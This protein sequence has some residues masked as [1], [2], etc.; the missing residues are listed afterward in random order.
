M[1]STGM[2]LAVLLCGLVNAANLPPA[3]A[4]E[5]ASTRTSASCTP[6]LIP[7]VGKTGMCVSTDLLN[8][9]CRIGG[10]EISQSN[11]CLDFVGQ[12][13][14]Y[15]APVR[16]PVIPKVALDAVS[17][18]PVTVSTEN[19]PE[20]T[21]NETTPATESET[22]TES[23]PETTTAEDDT[24]E[25]TNGDNGDS[26]DS[27][28]RQPVQEENS[29]SSSENRERRRPSGNEENN[30][31]RM[32]MRDRKRRREERRRPSRADEPESSSGDEGG[33]NMDSLFSRI[34]SRSKF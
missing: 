20:S 12:W 30:S 8:D 13:C 17:D 18:N 23:T 28:D 3:F 25:P 29:D 10:V 33:E 32:S 2:I 26:S 19:T 16:V 4:L 31:D 22:S 7:Q 5:L 11:D 34:F 24:T 21:P 14:C 15:I 6:T 27:S 1:Q 9:E